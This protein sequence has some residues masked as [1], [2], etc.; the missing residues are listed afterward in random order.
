VR[1]LE[2]GDVGLDE[3]LRLF[4]EGIALTR[5]CTELL[6]KAEARI[7]QLV[8]G[9]AGPQETPFIGEVPGAAS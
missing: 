7:T 6:D 4:E 3:S 9:P 5:R 8:E 2:A 1:K